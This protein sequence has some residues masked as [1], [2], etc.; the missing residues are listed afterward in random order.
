MPEGS[1]A[2]DAGRLIIQVNAGG[3]VAQAERGFLYP[4]PATTTTV[5][6]TVT[7]TVTVTT[8]PGEE[9]VAPVVEPGLVSRFLDWKYGQY[10]VGLVVFAL[11]FALFYVLSGIIFPRRSVLTEYTDL[12]DRRRDLGPKPVD[13]QAEKGG[14]AS[15]AAQ[16][17]LAVRGYQH[18]LQRL[19]DDAALKFRASE[20]A[21]L[22]L[23]G[24]IVVVVVLMVLS[25][26]LV[27]V[28][29]AGLIVVFLPLVWLDYKGR[30]RRQAFEN[31]VPNTLSLMAGSLRAGQGFEQAIAVAANEA[32][33]PTASEL[34]RVMAQQRLGV[35][36]EEALRDVAER[37]KSE[38]FD[39]VVMTTI[40]QRQ[41]G[42][43]LAEIYD[44]TANTLRERA[45]LQRQIKTLTAEGRLSAVILTILPFVIAAMVLIVNPGYLKPLYQTT[46]GL[47]M[48]GLGA[49]L[50]VLGILWMRSITRLGL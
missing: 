22:H 10:I 23:V 49:V 17:L 37:M 35:A 5:A 8:L 46:M 48:L 6:S 20:F 9:T 19:I 31:Q 24:V 34:R 27:L 28:L 7:T 26:P 39:W 44:S 16:R 42:G 3:A 2:A 11:L 38:A 15:R 13:E 18:P 25:V 41:V 43:N 36:P 45:K 1:Q 30:K 33:E 40:I 14:V 4:Q 47:I 29:L 32:P 50:M 12:L 21:L